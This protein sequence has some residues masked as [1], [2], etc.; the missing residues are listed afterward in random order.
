MIHVRFITSE[1]A[2]AGHPDKIADQIADTIVDHMLKQDTYGRCGVEVLVNSNLVVV[3]GEFKT[4][5]TLNVP[6]VVTKTINQIGYNEEE[7]GFYA[8]NL[9]VLTTIRQQS[10][11]IS[12]VIDNKKTKGASDQG[13]VFGY[14]TN[15][16]PEYMP[17]PF[18]LAA[19]LVKEMDRLRLSQELPYLRPDGKSQVTVEYHDG[20]PTRI[21][22]IVVA[23]Q[24][25]P[26][27]DIETVRQDIQKQVIEQIVPSHL[28]DAN[29]K[30]IINKLGRF[31]L[32]GPRIDTGMTGRK[33]VADTYGGIGQVG[34][35]ALSGKDPT[36]LDRSGA[37]Y[38]RYIAKNLVA[39]G[40]AE[41]CQLQIAYAFG[42]LNAVS[43]YLN[44]FGTS[45]YSEE[46]LIQWIT[47]VFP[48]SS[49]AMIDQMNLRR[50]IYQP[51]SV[52]GH[53][54]WSEYPWE[55]TD[56]V[57]HLRQLAK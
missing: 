15:E 20:K 53:F 56:T 48:L 23:A 2:A 21:E 19:K 22:A 45:P 27:T 37:Y 30:I 28:L 43:T 11:E 8:Q 3:S 24:H 35:G 34:G 39:A 16:T 29:T 44:T 17:M 52:Y 9:S 4:A 14:A 31:T 55:N 38:G 25:H 42:E 10:P 51:T 26:D 36:K 7:L 46:Q 5:A 40:L 49:Y 47:E 12:A 33:I 50:P 57:Q 41:K 13:I 1:C 18:M 32:G 6:D 54:G